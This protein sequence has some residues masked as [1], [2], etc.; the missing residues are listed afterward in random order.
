VCALTG[1]GLLGHN[2]LVHHGRI[3]LDAEDAVVQVN[4]SQDGPAEVHDV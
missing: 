2:R 4:L 1:V 3:G